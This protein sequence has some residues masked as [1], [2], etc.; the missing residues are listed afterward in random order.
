MCDKKWILYNNR[1]WPAQWLDWGGAPKHFPKQTCTRKKSWSL[2]GGLLP[3]WSTPAFLIPAKP[4]HQRSMLSKL[5][6]CPKNC[7]TWS[8]Y[9]STEWVQFCSTTMPESMLYNQCFRSWTNQTTK[10][11]LICHIHLTSCQL[12]TTFSKYL[13]NFWQGKYYHTQQEAENAFQEFVESRSV[14]F[15]ATGINK[16]IS[17]W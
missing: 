3:I 5:M 9:W 8:Q 4:L 16:L 13:S 17:H 7:N 14:N 11:C 15:Y 10:F 1:Q 6:R 12:T 2:F